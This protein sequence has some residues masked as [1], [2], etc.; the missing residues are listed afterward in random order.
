MVPLGE[1]KKAI[2]KVKRHR[3]PL[4]WRRKVK[5]RAKAAIWK[6]W[7]AGERS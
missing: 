5:G 6:S 2:L 3:T 4:H 1:K 7:I